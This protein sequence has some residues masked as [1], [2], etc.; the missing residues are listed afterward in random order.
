MTVF[1]SLRTKIVLTISGTL[2]VTV[3]FTMFF[4]QRESEKAMFDAEERNARTLVKTMA[5]NINNQ[6]K[7]LISHKKTAL[8]RKKSEAR[9]ITML[10][11]SYLDEFYQRYKAGALSE[12]KAK[13]L[14]IKKIKNLRYEDGSGYLWIN[15]TRKPFPRMIMHP[16]MPELDGKIL[17]NPEFNC[18]QGIKK[19]LFCAIVDSCLENDEGYVDYLWPKP[20]KDG[21]TPRQPK[22]SYVRIFKQWNWI[23]GTGFYVDD[24]E[25]DAK[26]RL[27][28]ILEEQTQTFSRIKI[29]ESGYL[30]I[31]TGKKEILVHPGHAGADYR[32]LT[33]PVT[34]NLIID[35]LIKAAKTPSKTFKYVWD[36]P[37]HN[38]NRFKFR[39]RSYVEYCE[40]LDWYIGSS[41]YEDEIREPGIEL[42]LKML[43]LALIF[44]AAALFISILLSRSLTG[45]LQKLT[46]TAKLLEKNGIYSEDIHIPVSGTEETRKL[47]AI[48][49]QTIQSIRFGVKEQERL[50]KALETNY[51]DLSQ[52]NEQLQKEIAERKR[53]EKELQ[54]LRNLL[55]NIIDSMPSVL[56]GVDPEGKVT[57]WNI[58]AEK[59][60]GIDAAQAQN[61][62]LTE[63]LPQFTDQMAEVRQAINNREVIKTQ[64]LELKI[65]EKIK[66]CD[67][68]LYPLVTPSGD[69]EGAVIRIDD[70]TQRVRLETMMIQTEKM[71]SVGGLAAGMAHEINNPLAGIL[72]NVQVMRNRL[73]HD[74][75]KNRRIAVGI[76]T[77][78]NTIE[79]YM[80]KRGIFL[81]L[82]SMMEMGKRAAKIVE[83]ML[84]FSR[85]SESRLSPHR[86]WK[87]LD[88]T[89]E[90]ASN[91]YDLKKKFDFRNIEIIREYDETLTRVWCEATKI[92]QVFL[93]ILK[94]GAQ[95]MAENE[96]KAKFTLRI[97]PDD[98]ETMVRIEM[99]DN[100]PGMEES[101]RKRVF[102][103]F[104]T[105]KGVGL[106]TGMGLA[107]SYFIISETHKGTI[108]VEN[109]TGGGAKVI[110]RLPFKGA[111]D[112][113]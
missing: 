11:I 36:K 58:E 29:A 95:A 1:N 62:L 86:I 70:V 76:G 15:D 2:L 7:S 39:K 74:M 37:P 73:K 45:P 93:N 113:S 81:M 19:N 94:N 90:L 20:A 79:E 35:E 77:T 43:L 112:E 83:N 25:G 54:Q 63:V 28:N 42:R 68:T 51:V 109:M 26:K 46:T 40:P 87:L 91:D 60:S 80:K 99:Q 33:N 101:T 104:F 38:K 23:L 9:N 27:R 92:Q 67:V 4:V 89:I 47:G 103:P 111:R 85:K 72:Q 102:E 41:V 44:L 10:A 64:K 53:A 106:G 12:E 107:V 56:V 3:I 69:V 96:K 75:P 6:Y 14:A 24:I 88:Q 65:K 16:T 49:E 18:A 55:S 21:L 30:Y 97:S 84:S 32:K 108:A 50:L 98:D 31:F 66:Y 82:E 78:M 110:I 61:K 8:D 100:G 59:I 13:K 22:V 5:L 34:G 105:T 52:T 57:R 17:D 48:L 71:V